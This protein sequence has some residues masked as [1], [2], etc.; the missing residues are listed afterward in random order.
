MELAFFSKTKGKSKKKKQPEKGGRQGDIRRTRGNAVSPDNTIRSHEVRAAS[1]DAVLC[2]LLDWAEQGS[3]TIRWTA[4][5]QL[6]MRD[7]TGN[8]AE[9]SSELA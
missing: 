3:L 9:K 8:S 5:C 7:V 4:H 2:Q 1:E 6:I